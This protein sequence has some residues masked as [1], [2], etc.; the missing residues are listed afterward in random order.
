MLC[1]T[2]YRHGAYNLI[3]FTQTCIRI[4][5]FRFSVDW[6]KNPKYHELENIKSDSILTDDEKKFLSGIHA[7]NRKCA[8]SPSKT[9]IEYLQ[10][11]YCKCLNYCI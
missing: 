8:K 7:R 5:L 11:V 3:I 4:S 2:M 6:L 1:Y 10:S 9:D